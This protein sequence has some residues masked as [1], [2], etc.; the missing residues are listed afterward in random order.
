MAVNRKIIF[1]ISI[2]HTIIFHSAY[3]QY[4]SGTMQNRIYITKSCIHN[5]IA[6]YRSQSLCNSIHSANVFDTF[7]KYFLVCHRKRRAS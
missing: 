2:N 6:S 3:T 4:Y 5:S 7:Q 1:I